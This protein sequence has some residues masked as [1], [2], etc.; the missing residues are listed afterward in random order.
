MLK[1]AKCFALLFAVV[2]AAAAWPASAQTFPNRPMRLIIGYGA[3][4]FNDVM[5]RIVADEAGKLLGQPMVVE[6]RPGA[7]G[8]LAGTAVKNSPPDGYTLYGGSVLEFHPILQKSSIDA[9]K[10]L[11][12]IANYLFGEWLLYVSGNI[13]VNSLKELV[14]YAKANPQKMRFASPSNTNFMLFSVIAKR[15][16]FTFENIPYKATDQTISAL[17]TGDCVVTLNATSG[18][19]GYVQSGKIKPISTLSP[20][21]SQTWNTVPSAAEQ[22]LDLDLR[23]NAGM[24][25]PLGMPSDVVNKLNATVREVVKTPSVVEKFRAASVNPAPLSP[26][27]LLKFVNDSVAT[28]KE[29]IALTGYQPQ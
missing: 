17:L 6:N 5:N 23:I 1:V 14:A 28:Y 20:S 19:E 8:M 24:W 4:G 3:G 9:T 7:S 18:F 26:E 2:A 10:E 16:G 29:A 13:G 12:P 25:G 22:G 27:E 11:T 21:R 15:N